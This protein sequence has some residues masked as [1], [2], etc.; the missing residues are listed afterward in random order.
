[1]E[2]KEKKGK[3]IKAMLSTSQNLIEC[4]LSRISVKVV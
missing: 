3:E 4:A 1:M 2:R